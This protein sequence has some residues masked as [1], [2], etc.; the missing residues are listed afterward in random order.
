MG[1]YRSDLSDSGREVV[2]VDG[3]Q[4]EHNLRLDN[5][6]KVRVA[7]GSPS[8]CCRLAGRGRVTWRW[9]VDGR[10]GG[11]PWRGTSSQAGRRGEAEAWRK[12]WQDGR[13]V[14]WVAGGW[15]VF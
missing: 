11:D 1:T 10:C 6:H 5:R 14:G 3:R 12:G 4:Q 15:V 9:L 2:L 8:A 13:R 7:V